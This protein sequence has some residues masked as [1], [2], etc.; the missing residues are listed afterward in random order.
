MSHV[1]VS[2]VAEVAANCH[3]SEHFQFS[4]S[5]DTE[6][7]TVNFTSNSSHDF[8]TIPIIIRSTL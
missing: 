7:F 1:L 2:V 5:P 6:R 3:F 8:H 4:T